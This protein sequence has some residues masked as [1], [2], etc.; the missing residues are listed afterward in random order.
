VD[1]G[2]AAPVTQSISVTVGNVNETPVMTSAATVSVA[3]NQTAVLTVTA[4]DPDGDALTYAIAGGVDAALFTINATT[5]ALSFV[6]APDFEAPTDSNGDNTYQVTV[7]TSDGTAAP[8][9]QTVSVA[10]T[11][12]NE[13]PSIAPIAAPATDEDAVPVQIDLLAGA[14]DPEGNPLVLTGPVTVTS[15]NAARTVTFSVVGGVLTLDPAQFGSMTQGQTETVTIAYQISDGSNPV[16]NTATIVVAGRDDVTPGQVIT[17]NGRANTLT[18]GAGDDTISG[19]GGNDVL[20]G[21]AGNDTLNG[22]A[23]TDT[24]NGDA[25]DDIILI[26]STE[27]QLDT[28]NGGADIDTL[29]LTGSAAVVLAGTSQ[30]TGIEVLDGGGLSLQG[31]SAANVLDLSGFTSVTGLVSLLGLSGNDTLT[32]SAFADTINGGIGTDVIDAGGG[33]DVVLIS[34]SDA[35]GDTMAGGSGND[36][37][38]LTG[39]AAVALTNTSQISGFEVLDGGGL[40]LTGTTGNN[41]LDLSVFATVTGLGVIDGLSGNDTLTGS[42]G[43]DTINGGAGTDTINAGDGDDTILISSNQASGDIVDGGFGVDRVLVLA[44]GGNVTLT[45]TTRMSGIESFDG[46]GVTINGSNAADTLDFRAIGTLVNVAAI[47]GGGGNDVIAGG[48]GNDTMTGGTGADAFIFA[49]GLTTGDDVITDFDAAGN[50]VIRLSG[51]SSSSNLAAA[52]TFD[53]QGALIDLDL[54]GGDGSIRL[55]GVT[56]LN[57]TTEDFL[58]T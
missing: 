19:L 21:A 1:D 5:G 34:G 17:G 56:S 31:T 20:N 54:I 37:L 58:F 29:R 44:A 57:Y 25:G 45:N 48:T 38:R 41:V 3:E 7:S 51:F 30:L 4:S 2:T 15:S 14:T 18:G 27:A 39:T 6:S 33:D 36:T 42:A 13:A 12:V 50:D 10:V 46:A 40:G 24:V 28:M 23:G 49:F 26:R 8:V 9:T 55:T 32:G 52:T 43:V 53:A 16:A 11:D 22:G 35:T 47:Q